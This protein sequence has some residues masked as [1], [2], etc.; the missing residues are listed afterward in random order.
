MPFNS[1]AM[2]PGLHHS[3]DGNQF[4]LAMTIEVLVH[5]QWIEGAIRLVR[6]SE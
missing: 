5:G 1:T 4:A 6:T 2:R 3:L